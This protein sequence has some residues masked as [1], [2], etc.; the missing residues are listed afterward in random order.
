ME[1][2]DYQVCISFVI[3]TTDADINHD[4]NQLYNHCRYF[5]DILSKK[6]FSFEQRTRILD[7]IIFPKKAEGKSNEHELVIGLSG[8]MDSSHLGN[9]LKKRPPSAIVKNQLFK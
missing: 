1:N 4:E 3:D 8:G 5:Y 9:I 7:E 2:K 6:W